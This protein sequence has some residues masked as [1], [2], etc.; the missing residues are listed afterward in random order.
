MGFTLNLKSVFLMFQTL[1]TIW[2]IER[3]ELR[4]HVLLLK[5]KMLQPHQGGKSFDL[6][7]IKFQYPAFK[8][9]V[10]LRRKC[11]V[12][13]NSRWVT[14]HLMKIRQQICIDLHTLCQS[15]ITLYK[16]FSPHGDC[17]IFWLVLNTPLPVLTKV[18]CTF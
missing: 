14:F 13:I 11:E 4:N 12:L 1:C 6:Y 16:I 18:P 8:Q 10:F 9:P 5:E 15:K 2:V 3:V 17:S 7:Q